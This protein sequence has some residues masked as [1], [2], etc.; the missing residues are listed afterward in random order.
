M[1][2]IFDISWPDTAEKPTAILFSNGNIG[3]TGSG[4][5]DSRVFRK[6][7]WRQTDSEVIISGDIENCTT[8][9]PPTKYKYTSVLKSNLQK[10][11]RRRLTEKALSTAKVMMKTDFIHFIRR[12]L[13]I[14]IEDAVLHESIAGIMWMTAAYPTW[15]PTRKHMDW[16]L[17]IV[18]HI[19]ELRWRDDYIY[20]N[21]DFRNDLE[22]IENLPEPGRTILY[23]LCFRMSYGGMKGDMN[24]LVY[25]IRLWMRRFAATAAI[26]AA[27]A[28]AAATEDIP[29]IKMSQIKNIKITELEPSAIDFHCWPGMLK[30]LAI[31][32][33]QFTSAEIKSAIW[34][35]SSS[36]NS[37][38]PIRDHSVDPGC[39]DSNFT[40]IGGVYAEI[41]ATTCAEVG[42]LAARYIINI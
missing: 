37:K 3:G 6:I 25:H 4:G 26:A 34:Y 20:I 29:L 16:L 33:P 35:Y 12:L 42:R 23:S 11:V 2:Y 41:W 31:K 8:S 27:T 30:Q 38:Q 5:G 39:R 13:I 24:M 17:S 15:Q 14:M 21:Y 36:I 18:S 22:T 9:L 1:N 7:K 32:F 19:S 40:D 10:C 28:M